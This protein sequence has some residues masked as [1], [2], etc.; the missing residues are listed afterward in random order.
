MPRKRLSPLERKARSLQTSWGK[1]GHKYSLDYLRELL[2]SINDCCVYCGKVLEIFN[3]SIDH[4]HPRSRGGT[5]KKSN[6]VYCHLGCNKAKGDLTELEYLG[7]KDYCEK[8]GIWTSIFRRL[9]ASG[10]MYR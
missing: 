9:R 7:L 3:V 10:F 2:I 8:V 6:L 4:K 1:L 5:N